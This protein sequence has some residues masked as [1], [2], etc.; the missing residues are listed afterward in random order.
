MISILHYD[1]IMRSHCL[2]LHSGGET[3]SEERDITL[4]T[5]KKPKGFNTL[6]RKYCNLKNG[7][8]F[9]RHRVVWGT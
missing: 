5:H 9:M 2:E 7:R 3:S 8:R 4:A 6:Y 1:I